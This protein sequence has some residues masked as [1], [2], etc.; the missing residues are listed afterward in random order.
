MS[1]TKT[2]LAQGSIAT[3]EAC[4]CGVVHVHVGAVSLRL[5]RTAFESL[6]AALVEANDRLLLLDPG[7]EPAVLRKLAL[8]ATDEA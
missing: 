5:T 2:I 6:T 3:V 4:D 7:P 8:V 1:T